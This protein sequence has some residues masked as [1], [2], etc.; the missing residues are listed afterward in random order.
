MTMAVAMAM[1]MAIMVEATGAKWLIKP[2]CL[3]LV[4][5][6]R[7]RGH[8]VVSAEVMPKVTTMQAMAEAMVLKAK[9]KLCKAKARAMVKL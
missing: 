9:A 8:W 1:A 5:Q 3:P 2:T 7:P 4:P 6:P